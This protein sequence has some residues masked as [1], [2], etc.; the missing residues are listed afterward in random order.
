MSTTLAWK[1]L[2]L[3]RGTFNRH[4][5]GFKCALGQQLRRRSK[6]DETFQGDRDGRDF[7]RLAVLEQEQAKAQAANDKHAGVGDGVEE[8]EQADDIPGGVKEYGKNEG[9]YYLQVYREAAKL[10]PLAPEHGADE[11]GSD[12]VAKGGKQAADQENL[13]H[14]AGITVAVHEGGK[15]VAHRLQR[16]ESH[17]RGDAEEQAVSLVAI[18]PADKKGDRKDEL[19]DFLDGTNTDERNQRSFFKYRPFQNTSSDDAQRA[20]DHETNP[21]YQDRDVAVADVFIEIGDEG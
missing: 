19:G 5:H 8:A 9:A 14:R 7:A 6:L 18:A 17:A 21:Q 12:G 13:L 11:S 2:D 16:C 3:D 1:D 10:S 4:G 20:A 15:T